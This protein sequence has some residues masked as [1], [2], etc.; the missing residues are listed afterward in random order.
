M[1]GGLTGLTIANRLLSLGKKTCLIEKESALGGLARS[2]LFNDVFF[3]FG[4]HIFRSN[5]E[6]IILYL[7]QLVN[8]DPY[9][10]HAGIYKYRKFFDGVIP[11][12]PRKN[13][14]NLPLNT[15]RRVY[16]ELKN[17]QNT[18]NTHD[19]FKSV[20]SSMVGNTLFKEFYGDYSS[21]WWGVKPE[22][23]SISLAPKTLKIDLESHYAHLTANFN[24]P[25]KEFYPK[26][27]GFGSIISSLSALAEEKKCTIIKGTTIKELSIDGDRINKL[28][29]EN[30]DEINLNGSLYSTIPI[31]DICRL[32][33]INTFLNYRSDICIFIVLNNDKKIKRMPF[34]WVYYPEERFKFGRLTDFS[35]IHRNSVPK[36]RIGLCAEITCFKGDSTWNDEKIKERVIAQLHELGLL[37]PSLII[38]SMLIKEPTAYPLYITGYQAEKQRVIE[39]ISKKA[40]NLILAGRTGSFT[41]LNSDASLAYNY[42]I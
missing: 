7:K 11:V 27:N 38:D 25:K 37:N 33:D 29:L 26:M 12:I 28:L 24:V 8:L 15:K 20:I 16:N 42:S 4:P 14:E 13:I 40:S 18:Q 23:L 3:D 39:K 32:L 34:S 41:Y 30:G 10:S 2:Y 1:G 36:N 22:S 21:K 6:K 17:I 19:N 9:K 31:T 35:N 5:D